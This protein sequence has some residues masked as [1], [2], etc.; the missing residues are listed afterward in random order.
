MA[1]LR[2]RCRRFIRHR[3]DALAYHGARLALAVPRPFSLERALALAD[4]VGDAGYFALP[5]LRRLALEHLDIAFG[6]AL[7]RGQR[8]HLARASMRNAARCFIELA[9]IEEVRDRFDEYT[10]AEGW[11]NWERIKQLGRGAI[12]ITG[13]L[14][15]WELLA[16]YFARA[17]IPIAAIAKRINDPRLN[18][19]LVDFRTA[20]GIRPILRESPSASREILTV[21]KDHG[22]LAML[23]DHDSRAPSVSVPFFGHMA[24][25]PAAA[26]TLAVRRNL[27]VLP[28]FAQRRP[29]GGHRFTLLEPVL[30]RQSGDRRADIIE[31]TGTFS[32]ILEARIRQN[33]A[34]WTWWHRR[35]RRPPLPQLD[36]DAEIQYS[37]RVL[38]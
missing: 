5:E 24:R 16:A 21:L 17:G 3:K 4:R 1:R 2:L 11:E 38:Q 13:H 30:P 8:E 35:R 7:A 32:A 36:L 26:A 25:T 9:K 15:N 10:S 31:L 23:I 6:G 18:Q 27:P 12:V 28:A 34:E 22:V 29:E 20:N 19:L 33:P 14:G 37:K